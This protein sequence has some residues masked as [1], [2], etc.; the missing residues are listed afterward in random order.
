MSDRFF[1][2]TRKGLFTFT[3]NGGE[4]GSWTAGKPAF[5][6]E[7]AMAA[8]KDPR[9]GT[10][11]ASLRMG[12]FG[13]KMRRSLDGG[14]T[15]EDIPT[16]RYAE[17]PPPAPPPSSP[18]EFEAFMALQEERKKGPSV[19]TIWILAAGGADPAA[20]SR[21]RTGARAGASSSRSGTRRSARSGWAAAQ[22]CRASTQSMSIRAIPRS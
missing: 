4:A 3:R 15:W 12:H 6:G 10:L 11:Y 7:S 2:A 16:P 14:E 13:P 22:I 21:A 19:D 8:L 17:E 5:L 1:V 20:C 18:E 9:D